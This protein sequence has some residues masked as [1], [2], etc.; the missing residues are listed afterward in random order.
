MRGRRRARTAAAGS[1]GMGSRAQAASSAAR[2][3]PTSR[4]CRPWIGCE[5]GSGGQPLREVRQPARIAVVDAAVRGV[6]DLAG[7]IGDA[8][9]GE[10]VA[11]RERAELEV[12]L[13]PGAAVEVD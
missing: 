1:S 11:E 10:R 3:A 2:T 9:L 4:V 7:H 5:A 8:D 6:E 13:V 12:P